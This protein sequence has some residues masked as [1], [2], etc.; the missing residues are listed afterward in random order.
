MRTYLVNH[1]LSQPD[2]SNIPILSIDQHLWS[3]VRTIIP[4]AQLAWDENALYVRLQAVEPHIRREYNGTLDPVWLDSCLEFFFCPEQHSNRYFNFE[5]NPNGSLFV[6][7]GNPSNERCRLHRQDWKS[8]L[9]LTIFESSGSWGLEMRIPVSF[10]KI[11]VPEFELY[12][13]LTLRANFYKC[14]DLTKQEHYIAWNPIDV[15]C[16]SFHSPQFFGKIQ[17]L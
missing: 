17:F 14:G 12:S 7:F 11:F 3:D 8:L 5:C 15:S 6:G 9:Q 1:V 13:G 2:W 4:S 16:R 10:I